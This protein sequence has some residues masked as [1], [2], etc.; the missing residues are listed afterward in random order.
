MPEGLKMIVY[1]RVGDGGEERVSTP[2]E[3]T[4]RDAMELLA[5]QGYRPANGY[6]PMRKLVYMWEDGR[7]GRAM[8]M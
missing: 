1:T 7:G 2:R 3:H 5:E 6:D 4:V 8:I